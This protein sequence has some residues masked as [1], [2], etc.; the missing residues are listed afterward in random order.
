ME[1]PREKAKE[2][3]KM[4]SAGIVGRF[5][6]WQPSVGKRMLRWNN[7]GPRRVKERPKGPAKVNGKTRVRGLG[8]S[9][10]G[11]EKATLGDHGKERTGLTRPIARRRM[12]IEHG[13]FRWRL[14]QLRTAVSFFEPEDLLQAQSLGATR[15]NVIHVG[16]ILRFRD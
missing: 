15:L 3:K 9:P 1:N 2:E 10:A 6:M 11:K 7:T 16:C 8:V 14:E 13:H 4:C 12:V 5:V